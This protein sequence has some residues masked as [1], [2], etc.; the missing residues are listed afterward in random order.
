MHWENEALSMNVGYGILE[1]M[2]VS[3]LLAAANIVGQTLLQLTPSISTIATFMVAPQSTKGQAKVF[4]TSGL[5]Y[6][7][8]WTQYSDYL[9]G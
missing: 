3:N 9:C 5:L 2:R 4:S 8:N 6:N 7:V 1:T